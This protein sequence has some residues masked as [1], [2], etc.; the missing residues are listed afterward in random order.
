MS[1]RREEPK[2]ERPEDHLTL[3]EEN[4]RLKA[5][6]EKIKIKE[7]NKKRQ[8]NRHQNSRNGKPKG[9]G[10]YP[11]SGKYGRG[12]KKREGSGNKRKANKVSINVEA[13]LE[14]C[15]KLWK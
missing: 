5:E 10:N 8:Q 2:G 4:A 12:K 1:K 15:Y 13:T 11:K 9:V 14:S 3:E 6:L 7:V